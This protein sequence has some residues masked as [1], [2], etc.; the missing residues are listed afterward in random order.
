[1]LSRLESRLGAGQSRLSLPI[2]GMENS[3][4]QPA[5]DCGDQRKERVTSADEVH[6]RASGSPDD[7]SGYGK[8]CQDMLIPAG[9]KVPLR[10]EGKRR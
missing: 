10:R 8:S 7:I 5:K 4:K 6:G 1:M 3:G 9:D 2:P